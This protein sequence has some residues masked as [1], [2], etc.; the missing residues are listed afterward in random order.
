MPTID[1]N[2]ITAGFPHPTVD[3][4]IGLP[5]YET[6]KDLQVQLNANTA[7]IFSNIGDGQHGLLLLAV[8]DA[9]YNSV[10]TVPFVQPMNPGPTVPYV[11]NAT[12]AQIKQAVDQH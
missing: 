4:I 9:Q 12:A 6:I 10:S 8:L 11:L 3:P 7:S 2:K 5:S 1:I